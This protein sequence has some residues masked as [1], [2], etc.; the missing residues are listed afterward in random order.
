MYFCENA[1]WGV[2]WGVNEKKRCCAWQT[3][4][5]C[6][7]IQLFQSPTSVVVLQPAGA[8]KQNANP[9]VE[10]AFVLALC[11]RHRFQTACADVYFLHLAVEH[12]ASFLNIGVE[13]P[14]DMTLREAD[15]IAKLGAF[16]TDL[17]FSHCF[18]TPRANSN[19]NNCVPSYLGHVNSQQKAPC[20]GA[21]R[22]VTQNLAAC[23]LSK[24]RDASGQPWSD[25]PTAALSAPHPSGKTV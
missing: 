13:S 16:S 25:F 1:G 12:H 9:G 15:M 2:K 6:G 4:P 14:L 24:S 11:F 19:C 7:N 20:A 23:K 10:L 3:R 21:K 22:S 18:T 5:T 8:P 17:T